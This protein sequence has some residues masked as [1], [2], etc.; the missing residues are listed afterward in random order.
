M[1]K[2]ALAFLTFFLLFF[3]IVLG[4][5]DMFFPTIKISW[6]DLL[7]LSFILSLPFS[8]TFTI[9]EER[10]TEVIRLLNKQPKEEKH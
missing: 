2:T 9:L 1:T 8:F 6:T 10:L 5:S 7:F 3:Q 4:V